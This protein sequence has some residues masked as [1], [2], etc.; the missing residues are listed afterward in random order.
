MREVLP[1]CGAEDL[2]LLLRK[3]DDVGV[4]KVE[5]VPYLNEGDLV[6]ILKPVKARQFME[7]AKGKQFDSKSCNIHLVQI[8]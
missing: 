8:M 7:K 4:D 3:L 5:D 1:A 2:A 6:G